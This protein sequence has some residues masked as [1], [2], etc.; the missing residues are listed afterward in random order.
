MSVAKKAG[1]H[2]GNALLD[3]LDGWLGLG[4]WAGLAL[5]GAGAYTAYS[6]V[7]KYDD[8]VPVEAEVTSVDTECWWQKIN[9][10]GGLGL[11]KTD[12]MP[13]AEA[14]AMAG[15]E[16]VEDFKLKE[17]VKYGFSFDHPTGEKVTVQRSM[18]FDEDAVPSVGQT[19]SLLTDPVETNKLALPSVVSRSA[20][21]SVGLMGGV[22]FLLFGVS[23]FLRRVLRRR[24]G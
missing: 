9:V 16:D 17:V 12:R 23:W 10:S 3:K 7:G 24:R 5:M 21:G 11:E 14:N 8:Y 2:V 6:S 4:F 15:S 22:G 20:W 19:V 13:C 1:K 18:A